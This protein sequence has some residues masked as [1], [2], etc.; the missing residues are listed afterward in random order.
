MTVCSVPNVL[1]PLCEHRDFL[2]R[3]FATLGATDE[4]LWLFLCREP[5]RIVEHTVWDFFL[6]NRHL[7]AWTLPPRLLR[8][9]CSV[10]NIHWSLMNRYRYEEYM[11]W[12]MNEISLY[13]C[14]KSNFV[15][16]S[17]FF[18]KKYIILL[19]GFFWVFHIK[20]NLLYMTSYVWHTKTPD[21]V[22]KCISFYVHLSIVCP[23][24]M[25]FWRTP[26]LQNQWEFT[27]YSLHGNCLGIVAIFIC[28]RPLENFSEVTWE[29]TI[30]FAC[31]WPAVG[32]I[33][34]WSDVI[35]HK[36]IYNTNTCI[37]NTNVFWTS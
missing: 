5:K 7:I 16:R 32:F 27:L 10:R 26:H 15:K 37:Y 1:C 25:Q 6:Y 14:Y 23:P 31:I 18:R 24:T 3:D 13:Q 2:T 8:T 34:A 22:F 21:D 28:K 19:M 17:S 9:P 12:M 35:T 36:P 33:I 4:D 20:Q 30:G 29:N 11:V